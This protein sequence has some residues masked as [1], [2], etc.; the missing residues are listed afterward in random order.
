VTSRIL[1][2]ALAL[3]ATVCQKSLGV[4]RAIRWFLSAFGIHSVVYTFKNGINSLEVGRADD[5]VR[6]LLHL[7]LV[8]KKRQASTALQYLEGKVSGNT[9][10]KVYEQEYKKHKRKNNPLKNLGLRLPMTRFQA[11]AAAQ[12]KSR[13]ARNIGIRRSFQVR[14]RARVNA[15]PRTFAVKDIERVIG[16]SKPRAQVLG[17]IMEREGF[18]RSHFEKV[19]P[20]FRKKVFER[21]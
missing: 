15:L 16:V 19:P 7:K 3:K 12:A 1:S 9:L 20:R 4:I 8:V 21:T 5:L 2:N 13:R 11:V 18:V 10:L 17:N 14:L 6:F